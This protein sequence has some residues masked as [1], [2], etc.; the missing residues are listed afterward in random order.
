MVY[1]DLE[2]ET[3][4]VEGSMGSTKT[5]SFRTTTSLNFFLDLTREAAEADSTKIRIVLL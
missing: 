5:K 4:C 3:R 2:W 1:D